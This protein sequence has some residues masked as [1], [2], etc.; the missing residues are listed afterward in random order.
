M[1]KMI[2]GVLF[3]MEYVYMVFINV[4]TFLLIANV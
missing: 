1:S 3:L 4:P 2:T